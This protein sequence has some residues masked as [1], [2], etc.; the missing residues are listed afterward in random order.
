V[1]VGDAFLCPKIELFL[2]NEMGRLNAP[3]TTF[4]ALADCF[5]QPA[6]APGAR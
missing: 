3:E 5:Q 1:I 4:R 6:R 2:I